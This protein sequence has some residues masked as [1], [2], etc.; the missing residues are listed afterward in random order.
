MRPDTI[1]A[2]NAINRAFYAAI[3]PEWSQSRRHAWPGFAPLLERTLAL[4]PS[5]SQL[6]VLD[7]G[8]GDGRFGAY[9][10]Q[11]PMAAKVDYLGLDASQALL[12]HATGRGLGTNYRFVHADFVAEPGAAAIPAGPYELCVLLG[13][14][15]HVPSFARRLELLRALEDRLS[16]QGVCAFTVWRLDRDPRFERRRLDFAEYNAH[17]ERPIDLADLEPGDALVRWGAGSAPPRYCHFPSESELEALLAASRLRVHARFSAD[18]KTG[19]LND[20]ILTTRAI[21]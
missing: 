13:V 8:A 1:L 5:R 18:G 3:A 12:S 11:Q 20:Y 21:D 2:L 19:A 15:H 14:L 9:L 4:A 6:R 10:R 16:P 7:V 17:A